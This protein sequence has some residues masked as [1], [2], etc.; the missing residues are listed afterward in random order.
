MIFVPPKQTKEFI[1]SLLKLIYS[2]WRC[3][4]WPLISQGF[5]ATTFHRFCQWGERIPAPGFRIIFRIL[6]I[7]L[8]KVSEIL[9]G[10]YIGVNAEIGP[11][12]T[13]EHFSGIIIHADVKIGARVR[14]RQGVT[15]GNKSASTSNA[16]PI[17]HDGVD[18][19][20]GAKILGPIDIGENAIIGANAV[21]LCDVPA[22]QIAVGVPARIRTV[23]PPQV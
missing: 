20:A 17:L 8:T 21:V 19:G 9:F 3:Y 18:V 15:I 2:D 23:Q 14:L 12:L 1:I 6:H 16:V 10:I 11:A 5:W 4:R 13:I 7:F 22:G